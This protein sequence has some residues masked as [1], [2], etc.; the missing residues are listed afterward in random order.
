MDPDA[1]AAAGQSDDEPELF[2]PFS[3]AMD[4]VAP[5]A[6]LPGFR[7]IRG[8]DA[9][10]MIN[11]LQAQLAD[12]ACI[13]ASTSL[14]SAEWLTADEGGAA[15]HETDSSATENA[16]PVARPAAST[17]WPALPPWMEAWR[18]LL[19]GAAGASPR[20][21]GR[22]AGSVAPKQAD[23]HKPMAPQSTRIQP[24]Q[25]T[26]GQRFTISMRSLRTLGKPEHGASDRWGLL[27]RVDAAKARLQKAMK[28]CD[29]ELRSLEAVHAAAEAEVASRLAALRASGS[30]AALRAHRGMSQVSR[31]WRCK[32][33]EVLQLRRTRLDHGL[34]ELSELQQALLFASTGDAARRGGGA[35]GV[36]N[37][38]AELRARVE[39]AAVVTE[40]ADEYLRGDAE[41]A[42]AQQVEAGFSA[43][44]ESARETHDAVLRASRVGGKVARRETL[45]QI[46][47]E[48]PSGRSSSGDGASARRTSAA[49]LFSR[50]GQAERRMTLLRLLMA[51][52]SA[53]R[54][55]V[56]RWL[57]ALADT[58]SLTPSDEKVE[59]GEFLLPFLTHMAGRIL[60]AGAL[61]A[62]AHVAVIE[63][64]SRAL[65]PLAEPLVLPDCY[66]R[67]AAQDERLRAQQKM[68]RRLSPAELEVEGCVPEDAATG[69][70]DLTEVQDL[71]SML[72][73]LVYMQG[74]AEFAMGI[75]EVIAAANT[76]LVRGAGQDSGTAGADELMPLM[77]LLVVHAHLP[78]GYALLQ[79]VK[80][81]LEPG[82]INSELGYCLCTF[83]A[84]MEHVRQSD[85][86]SSH[87]KDVIEDGTEVDLA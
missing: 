77:V 39:S 15:V 61:P 82:V 31:A 75:H 25:L 1:A 13:R 73:G 71:L 35:G 12:D 5:R 56:E 50:M 78:R 24:L 30:F 42:M 48:P 23:A 8:S 36:T 47:G 59:R 57:R 28:P 70:P 6:H 62:S 52:G 54:R 63:L 16:P 74:P 37:A 65:L 43:M 4:D 51:D 20:D 11:V 46:F 29:G 17:K 72:G 81:T 86:Y 55:L 84:A 49:E 22:S 69:L 19:P 87:R 10:A 45:Q 32:R 44:S 40:D 85:A 26:L 58:S 68:L 33:L 7:T 18:S 34:K 53:E 83:E 41:L 76:F 3:P 60:D 67:Y 14:A 64:T 80:A 9:Q 38:E 2:P 79:H 66:E 21:M 27:A